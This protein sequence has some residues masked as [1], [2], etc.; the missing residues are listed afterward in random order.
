M[1]IGASLFVI[2]VGAILKWAV[3]AHVNGIN[4]QVMGV[5][6]M[7]IGIVWLVF[8]CIWW[9]SRRQTTVVTRTPGATYVD[10]A[11][12]PPP[13]AERVERY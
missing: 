5:I 10:P 4:L 6:L 3:T 9:A 13:P 8:E 2:A 7:V 1:R 11:Q 12:M